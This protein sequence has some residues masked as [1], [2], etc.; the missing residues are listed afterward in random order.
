[1]LGRVSGPIVDDE[2]D[3]EILFEDKH[4]VVAGAQS[5]WA[6]RRKITL[7]ELID[8]PWIHMPPNTVIGSLIVEA[9][10]SQGLKV[11][12]TSVSTYSM[13]LRS[14]LLGSGR[15]LTIM[16]N[17]MLRFNFRASNLKAL[18]IELQIRPRFT[19]VVTL[20]NRTLGPVT[21]L[22]IEHARAVAKSMHLPLR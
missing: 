5:P 22:F 11:P 12:R 9:F 21:Q 8:E 20:K 14:H 2:L 7:A 10:R 15:F 17:S 16:P 18:P 19:A 1:M 6:R 13:H 3:A 4:F